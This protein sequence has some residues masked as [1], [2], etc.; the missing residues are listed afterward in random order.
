MTAARATGGS[1]PAGDRAELAELYA[2][3]AGC[4]T[5]PDRAFRE[6]VR[7]G[8]LET[9]LRELSAELAVDV[10]S[11]PT[12][13]VDGLREAYLRTFEAY[14]GGSYAPPVESVYEEW[15]DG[16]RRELTSGPAAAEMRRR[17]EAID[18]EPP[19]A[20]PA[21]HLAPLLEYA[22]LLLEAGEF[23]AYVQFHETH[24]DWIPAFR[25]R[26]EDTAD[27]TFYRW[28]VRTTAEVIEATAEVIGDE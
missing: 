12:D 28:A 3:L 25:R 21:D 7:S 1:S 16:S 20:Y 19:E 15:W 5:P 22:S 8:R 23:E 14:E 18:A 26:V 11:P 17:Y 27:S 6:A 10:E 9:A 24:F 2:A 4:F 13:D